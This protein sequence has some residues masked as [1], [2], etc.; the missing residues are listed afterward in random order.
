MTILGNAYINHELKLMPVLDPKIL[1]C[2]MSVMTISG[3]AYTN[4]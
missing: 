1:K 4:H 3:N 2:K